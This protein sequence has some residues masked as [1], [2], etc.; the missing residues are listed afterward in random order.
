MCR[1][2]GN[3]LS[4]ALITVCKVATSAWITSV[5]HF[6]L[7]GLIAINQV[8]NFFNPT[9]PGKSEKIGEAFLTFTIACL[10][11]QFKTSLSRRDYNLLLSINVL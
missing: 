10:L 1:R 9:A 11:R 4:S 5:F 2:E 3:S 6:F 8:N 7:T